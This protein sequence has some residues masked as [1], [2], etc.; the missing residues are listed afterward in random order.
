MSELKNRLI[1]SD[2]KELSQN[3]KEVPND[4]LKFLIVVGQLANNELSTRMFLQDTEK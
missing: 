1:I 4:L 3:I 2:L